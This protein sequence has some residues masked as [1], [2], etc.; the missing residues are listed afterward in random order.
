MPCWMCTSCG[1]YVNTGTP[2]DECPQCRQRCSFGNVT[3]YRPECGGER[4]S[5]P[6]IMAYVLDGMA[7]GN[8]KNTTAGLAQR[9]SISYDSNAL[10]YEAALIALRQL[11]DQLRPRCRGKAEQ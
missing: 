11:R 5:D 1:H 4:N 3:C 2:P 8:K 7:A 10:C 6:K 9:S